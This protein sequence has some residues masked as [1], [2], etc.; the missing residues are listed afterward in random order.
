MIVAAKAALGSSTLAYRWVAVG[1]SG[2]LATSDSATASSWT[3]RTSSFGTTSV[4]AVASDGQGIYV[5]VGDAGKIATSPDGITWTQRTNPFGSNSIGSI[6]YGNGIWVAAGNAAASVT[7]VAT[8]TDP[9][10]TWTLRTTG[11]TGS[12]PL[13]A[14]GGG[15]WV[16]RQGNAV[17]T[18]TD[19]TGTW[20]LQTVNLSGAGASN[21]PPR[22]TNFASIWNIGFDIAAT[23]GQIDSSPNGSTWTARSMPNASGLF[24]GQAMI[25]SSSSVIAIAYPT[26]SALDIATSTDGISWTDRTPAITGTIATAAAVDGSGLLV[27]ANGTSVQTSSD[28]TTWTSRTGPTFTPLGLCHS[29][30]S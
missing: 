16:M 10:G 20:T 8:A 29:S 2:N 23:T 30:N 21:F 13:V 11:F 25:T 4:N 7:Q 6:A 17:R 3:A 28:G 19:P 18:A 12:G 22:Y 5:A 15:L 1:T 27:F 24:G 14:F 9:T 26:S